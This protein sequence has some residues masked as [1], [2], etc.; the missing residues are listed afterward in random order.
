[1]RNRNLVLPSLVIVCLLT[2]L[3][4]LFSYYLWYTEDA[5]PE[6]VVYDQQEEAPVTIDEE[7][8]G[9]EAEAS[10]SI[11]DLTEAIEQN[12]TGEAYFD[13]GH[14][15]H[16]IGK[17][18]EAI[19]DLNEA[20]RL[21]P[22]N[23]YAYI[24]RAHAVT[25]L[26][27][28]DD[29]VGSNTRAIEDFTKALELEPENSTQYSNRGFAYSRIGDSDSALS[30]FNRAIELD[31]ENNIAYL[32]RSNLYRSKGENELADADKRTYQSLPS[33]PPIGVRERRAGDEVH[34]ERYPPRIISGP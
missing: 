17:N 30:D 18:E 13:R 24:D 3:V 10:V 20:I 23:S 34:Y 16:R 9:E 11:E 14:R 15:Y 22:T 31:P 27:F 28:P 12:P 7:D 26:G 19:L 8:S 29:I 5:T 6:Q 25:R 2:C 1:M 21:D 4:T 33:P 32:N